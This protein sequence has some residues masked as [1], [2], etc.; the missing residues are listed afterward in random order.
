[1]LTV[2]MLNVANKLFLLS[3]VILNVVELSVVAPQE[4]S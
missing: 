2:V 1:M 4:V 3:A